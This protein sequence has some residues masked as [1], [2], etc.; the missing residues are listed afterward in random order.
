M[1]KFYT[2]KFEDGTMI[3]NNWNDIEEAVYNACR[4]SRNDPENIKE[5][6]IADAQ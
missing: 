2:V 3:G 5:I 1:K 4:L 6:L